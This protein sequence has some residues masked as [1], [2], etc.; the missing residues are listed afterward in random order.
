M[1][2]YHVLIILNIIVKTLIIG[3]CI[4]ILILLLQLLMM[5]LYPEVSFADLTP[6]VSESGGVITIESKPK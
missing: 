3:I 6:R 1:L 5:K 4:A 2:N